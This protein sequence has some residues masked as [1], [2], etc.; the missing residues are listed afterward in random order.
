MKL[1]IKNY[2]KLGLLLFGV[3]LF[4]VNCQKDDSLQIEN[5]F[6]SSQLSVKDISL[7]TFY[8]KEII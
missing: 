7:E 2:L 6:N 4:L 5:T 8:N 1:Q 3:P